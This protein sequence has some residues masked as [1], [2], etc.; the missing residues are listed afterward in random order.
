MPTSGGNQTPRM[1]MA[2]IRD[3]TKKL[4]KKARTPVSSSFNVKKVYADSQSGGGTTIG[5]DQ[6]YLTIPNNGTVTYS[7]PL[8]SLSSVQMF[9]SWQRGTAEGYCRFAGYHDGSTGVFRV[10]MFR[11]TPGFNWASF[12]AAV[13]GGN[14]VLTFAADSSGSDIELSLVV[15]LAAAI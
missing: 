13:S 1:D 14:L 11:G 3:F 12:A 4:V 8:S 5:N 9:G 6:I 2:Y 15:T 10:S 7:I